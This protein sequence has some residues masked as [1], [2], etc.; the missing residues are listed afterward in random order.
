MYTFSAISEQ[1]L[2][3]PAGELYVCL[4]GRIRI[5]CNTSAAVLLE[6]NVTIPG[7]NPLEAETRSFQTASNRVTTTPIVVN[8]AILN[9]S[10]SF[11]LVSEIFTENATAD[12][13]GILI[14]CT[15]YV[16]LIDTDIDGTS[17]STRMNMIRN[18]NGN[19]NSRCE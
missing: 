16:S 7:S 15:E 8:S 18:D 6:W 10:R 1:L 14:T 5:R 2:L 13:N 9:I 12:L 3:E 17:A 11:P 4:G 19:V